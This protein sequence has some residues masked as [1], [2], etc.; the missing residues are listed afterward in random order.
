MN[1]TCTVPRQRGPAPTPLE[2]EPGPHHVS[3]D[4]ES[5]VVEQAKGVLMLR[6]GVGSYE[7]FAVLVR[8]SH[9]AGVVL[10]ESARALMEGVCKGRVAAAHVDPWLVRWLEQ[11]LRTDVDDLV[12]GGGSAH[13]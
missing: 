4:P 8:W 1:R 3:D 13:G 5:A 10:Q 7:A 12:P 2:R 11:R 6:Y 9:E